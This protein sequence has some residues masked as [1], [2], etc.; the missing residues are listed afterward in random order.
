ML[1]LD[2]SCEIKRP[3]EEVFAYLTDPAKVPEWNPAVLQCREEPSGPVQVGSKL[4][5]VS[6]ILGRR[7]E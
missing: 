3:V 7:F 1:K 6:R 5:K 4:H 2:F